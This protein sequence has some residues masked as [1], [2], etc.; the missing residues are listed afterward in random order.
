ME[1]FGESFADFLK[2]ATKKIEELQVQ[3]ALGKAELSDYFEDL[4]KESRNEYHNLKSKFNSKLEQ[5]I[6]KKDEI[7]RK[8][9]HLELQLA[10]GKAESKEL[11]EEQ[12][13]KLKQAFKDVS[14]LI[15]KT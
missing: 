5:T 2:T 11:L 1:H 9:E 8:L 15:N 14:D 3:A 10:L 12:K 13:I 4:K 6:E 7:Q